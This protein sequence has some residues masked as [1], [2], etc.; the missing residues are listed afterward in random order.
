M[1]SQDSL[2]G[3]ENLREFERALTEAERSLAELKQRYSQFQEAQEQLPASE[4]KSLRGALGEIQEK[5]EELDVYLKFFLFNWSEAKEP[6]WQAVR[7]GGLG[8]V[9]GWLLKLWA[10]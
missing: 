9:I 8:V 6:F 10:G 4:V 1:P 3:Q 5:L 2:Q 7:F